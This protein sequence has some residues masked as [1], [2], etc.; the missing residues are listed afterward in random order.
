MAVSVCRVH[1]RCVVKRK[2]VSNQQQL[3][4]NDDALKVI[5]KKKGTKRSVVATIVSE[6]RWRSVSVVLSGFL[7]RSSFLSSRGCRLELVYR[8][9]ESCTWYRCSFV[10]CD[11]WVRR[12]SVCS[13]CRCSYGV[14]HRCS[15]CSGC[16]GSR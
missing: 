6:R 15:A 11:S 10:V 9:C 12:G 7:S 16:R 14:R 5:G 3:Q 4:V 1:V 2:E 8:E 13:R